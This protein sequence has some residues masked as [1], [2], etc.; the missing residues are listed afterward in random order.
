MCK[1]HTKTTCGKMPQINTSKLLQIIT[2]GGPF[3]IGHKISLPQAS[4]ML[5]NGNVEPST[6]TFF[7]KLFTMLPFCHHIGAYLIIG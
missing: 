3:Q 4:K 2:L 7:R 5:T 6:R 1:P